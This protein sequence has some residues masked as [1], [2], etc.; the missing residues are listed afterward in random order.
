MFLG[1]ACQYKKI[2]LQCY[3][4]TLNLLKQSFDASLDFVTFCSAYVGVVRK[5]HV[6]PGSIGHICRH[7][8]TSLLVIRFTVDAAGPQRTEVAFSARSLCFSIGMNAKMTV[9][10][11][12]SSS[13]RCHFIAQCLATDVAHVRAT[14]RTADLV[15]GVHVLEELCVTGRTTS[16]QGFR[17]RFGRLVVERWW[18]W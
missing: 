17:E 12:R 8:L 10:T 16:H 7:R 3:N 2:I 11:I 1:C 14:F 6:F 9:P 15:A 4:T 18:R 5:Q 13:S